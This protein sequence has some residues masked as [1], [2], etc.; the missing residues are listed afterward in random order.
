MSTRRSNQERAKWRTDCRNALSKHISETYHRE[1]IPLFTKCSEAERLGLSVE[2]SQVRLVPGPH[3]PY[4]WDYP[5]HLKTLF[6]KNM[7]KQTVN[8]YKALYREV[9]KSFKVAPRDAHL[10]LGEGQ[11]SDEEAN[12]RVGS[13]PVLCLVLQLKPN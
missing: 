1:P 4:M 11:G 7:S 2:P 6:K 5:P 10:D 12:S 8:V 13:C 9:G 3:D